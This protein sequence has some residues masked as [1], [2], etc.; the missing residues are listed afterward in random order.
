MRGS[1]G[2]G[3]RGRGGR[4]L[5]AAIGSTGYLTLEEYRVGWKVDGDMWAVGRSGG[6]R[7]KGSATCFG[8]IEN[9]TRLFPD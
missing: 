5:D 1:V 2:G 6:R 9:F 3:G 4:V 7:G 8:Q